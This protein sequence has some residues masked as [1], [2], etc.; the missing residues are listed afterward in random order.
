[1]DQT[2]LSK[3]DAPWFR[4][5]HWQVFIAMG[6]GTL[7]GATFGEAAANQ[8]GWIGDLFM[9]LLRMIIV[10]LVVTSIIAGVATVGGGRR[11]W[12]P[13]FQDVRLLRAVQLIRGIRRTPPRQCDSP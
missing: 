4:R 12:S 10:P 3:S 2:L 6:L 13:V 5:L 1:M 11:P 8:I 7:T 9:E